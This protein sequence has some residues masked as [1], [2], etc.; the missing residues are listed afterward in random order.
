MQAPPVVLDST[1]QQGNLANPVARSTL[2]VA[3]AARDGKM[4]LRMAL[5]ALEVMAVVVAVVE[6]QEMHSRVLPTL[7]AVVVALRRASV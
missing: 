4:E 5:L 6:P 1:Q 3:V 2:A 7:V